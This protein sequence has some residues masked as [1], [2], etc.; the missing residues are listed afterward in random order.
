MSATVTNLPNP[1][2]G[3]TAAE[4]RMLLAKVERDESAPVLQPVITRVIDG[5]GGCII[6]KTTRPGQA[7]WI[8]NSEVI[9]FTDD[10]G[11]EWSI[12]VTVTAK[13]ALAKHGARTQA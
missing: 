9:P 7:P 4:L 1:A 10:Q 3:M 11:R 2:S 5:Q 13:N 12:K 6:G 8:G